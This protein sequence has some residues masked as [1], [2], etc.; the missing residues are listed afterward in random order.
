MRIQLRQSWLYTKI[1]YS[2]LSLLQTPWAQW[3]YFVILKFCYIRVAKTIKYKEMLNFGTKKITLLYQ[4]FCYNQ[5]P[6]YNES[7]LYSWI[8]VLNELS[9]MRPF[10]PNVNVNSK[11]GSYNWAWLSKT[12]GAEH[13]EATCHSFRSREQRL[14]SHDGKVRILNFKIRNAHFELR[15]VHTR[16]VIAIY[17][18]CS[19]HTRDRIWDFAFQRE[20]NVW[21]PCQSN[22]HGARISC[23]SV[24]IKRMVHRWKW[25]KEG[26]LQLCPPNH[27]L[28]VRAFI[29]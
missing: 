27:D 7:P 3:N 19:V 11:W 1:L 24:H 16:E 5:C 18:L 20:K 12:S 2:G 14:F 15:S 21:V 6:L 26:H 9:C 10:S 25:F 29:Q 4:G 28:E 17:E 13:T 22:M 23:A 8:I